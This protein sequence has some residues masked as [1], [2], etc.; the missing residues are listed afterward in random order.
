MHTE[1]T[2]TKRAASSH[3]FLGLIT[4]GAIFLGAQSLMA[5]IT[6]IDV[7]FNGNSV[8]G[9]FGGG[10]PNPGPNY[11]G[12]AVLGQAGDQWNSIVD[13]QLTFAEPPAYN[14]S[15]SGLTLTNVDGSASGVTMS[16][17]A[18]GTFDAN[19]PVWG[20]TS[21]F[22][23]AGSPFSNLMEDF[24]FATQ[25]FGPKTVTL[26]GLGANQTFD[27][28][29]YSAGNAAA[30]QSSFTVNGVTKTSTYDNVTTTLVDGV[31]YVRYATATSDGSGNLVITYFS[32]VVA[33]EANLNG[34]Q[35]QA[36]TPIPEPSTYAF[37]VAG[38]LALLVVRRVRR[39][40]V[41]QA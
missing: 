31:T 3:R 15:A 34:F 25:E 16:L 14:G 7:D 37:A 26:S 36:L 22:T 13:T 12:A 5:T 19:E 4:A 10:G 24:L 8:G 30:R 18:R 39:G 11:S 40:R 41:S 35:L 38:G 6:L 23:V 27:L 33:G 29:L 21:P 28:V 32:N 9:S 1:V 17:T 2:L 20:S